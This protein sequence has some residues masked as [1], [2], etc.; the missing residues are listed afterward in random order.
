[1]PEILYEVSGRVATV[2]LN[3]PEKLNAWTRSMEQEVRSALEEAAHDENVRVI[4][5]TGAGRGFCA[6]ADM[7][8]LST[9]ATGGPGGHPLPDSTAAGSDGS[10]VARSDFA[11]QYSYFP[12]IPKP[13]IA[14]INGPAVGLGFVIAMYCDLRFASDTARFGSAFAR[15]GL[16]AE[17]GVAW[18][19]PKIVGHAN[20]MDILLSARV[21]D[22]PEA[23]RMGLVNQVF[24]QDGFLDR[25]YAY[26]NDLA[27]AVSP[28]S[29]RVIKRQVYEAMFQTLGGALDTA[30]VEMKASLE[31]EDFKE[32]VAHFVEKRAPQFT[33]R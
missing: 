1:M 33:G 3:R 29:L 13:I 28:R 8:L 27:N 15:R 32:G 10:T 14:A 25:V 6:G 30:T 7:S 2:T 31:C 18:L 20:A 12:A 17:Y 11:R 21:L 23:L 4:V 26:A 24:P 19:L 16:I 9:I 5:M 22:A